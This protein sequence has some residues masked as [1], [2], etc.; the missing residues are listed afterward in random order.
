[1]DYEKLAAVLANR[2]RR[3]VPRKGLAP[4][5]VTVPLFDRDG[6]THVLFTLRTDKVK[7]HKG[8]ISFPGG[9]S[10][11]CDGSI[12]ETATRETVEEVGIPPSCIHVLGQIDDTVTISD[13]HV[14]PV[15]ARVDWPFPTKV[16][17]DEIA[18]LIEVPLAALLAPG[19][20]RI[21]TW[22]QGDER[23]KMYF[24]DFGEYVI[25]GA[26]ARILRQFL[27]IAGNCVVAGGKQ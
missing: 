19:T 4:S 5:G 21:E 13:F 14:T 17:A 8:Q 23:I 2:E 7:H 26:T 25:W 15:V 27:D 24:Y 20:P 9:A 1:M 6:A 16:C 22:E 10:E 18:R 3:V 11:A 12:V